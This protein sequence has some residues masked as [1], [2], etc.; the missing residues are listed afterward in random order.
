[1][2]ERGQMRRWTKELSGYMQSVEPFIVLRAV[3]DMHPTVRVWEILE[4]GKIMRR[5]EDT[6]THNSEVIDGQ[7]NAVACEGAEATG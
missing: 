6:I 3:K 7:G 4:A 1:M 2:V 5:Y